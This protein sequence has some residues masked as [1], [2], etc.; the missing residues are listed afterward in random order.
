M[1]MIYYKVQAE[2]IIYYPIKYSLLWFLPKHPHGGFSNF[3]TG[4]YAII[5]TTCV[6]SETCYE[7]KPR[8]KNIYSL[9]FKK[10]VFITFWDFKGSVFRPLQY[11]QLRLIS[12]AYDNLM[13]MQFI[14]N[15]F[16]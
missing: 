7:K 15:P 12:A 3:S 8:K 9:T 4:T 14:S 1:T 5:G 16:Q 6:E 11:S 13:Q 2:C 10:S